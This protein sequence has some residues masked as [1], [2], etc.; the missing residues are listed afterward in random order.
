MVEAVPYLVTDK[1]I[2]MF[3]KH[4]VYSEV[5]L[6]SRAE[7]LYESYS[8]AINIEAKTMIEMANKKYIP[9]V[10]KFTTDLAASINSVKSACQAADVTVQEE[11]LTK[12]CA[13]LKEAKA[14]VVNLEKAVE[15]AASKEEGEE[16]ALYFRKVVFE[17]MATVRKPI[18]ELELIVDKE[19]WPVPTY[20]DLLFEV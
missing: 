16:M 12:T 8:K 20:G 11:L 2:K 9:A 3:E 18:D 4:H 17:T 13:L 5:E 7:I 14:A 1:A 6:K 10:I 15:E 19:V